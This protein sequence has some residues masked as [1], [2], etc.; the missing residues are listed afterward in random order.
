MEEQIFPIWAFAAVF[1]W[2]A[3][4]SGASAIYRKSNGKP[5]IPR[6]PQGALFAER[7]GSSTWANNCL[8]VSV[9]A[10]ELRVVPFFPFTLGFLPEIYR[11][12]QRVSVR[13]IRSVELFETSWGNN[14]LIRYGPDERALKLK[15]RNPE[16]LVHALSRLGARIAKR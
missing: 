2:L 12:D 4:V 3:L 8:L 10:D 7:F 5:I 14:V 16:G 9:T 13:T 6:L 11:L 15:L 1:G